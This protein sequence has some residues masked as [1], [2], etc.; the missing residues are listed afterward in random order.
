MPTI[1]LTLGGNLGDR[2]ASLRRGVALLAPEV[3][4]TA[5]SPLYESAPWG[6][7]DQPPFLNAVLC[8]ETELED[9]KGLK[10]SC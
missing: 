7:T 1:Y 10:P 9:W 5:V 8:G 6:V 4:V 3:R 2:E